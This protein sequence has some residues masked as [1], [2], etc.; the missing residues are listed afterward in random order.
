MD[1]PIFETEHQLFRESASTFV[2]RSVLPHLDDWRTQRRIDREAWLEAGRGG[3]L[4]ISIPEEFGGAGLADD[5]RFNAVLSEE[6]AKASMGLSSSFGIHTDVVAP[7]LIAFCDQDQKERWLPGFCAGDLITAIAMTEP[8]AGSDLAAIKTRARRDGDDW[9]LDGAKTFITNGMSA[10][11]VIIA[12]RTGDERR[13]I[14]L[15]V[16]E[17]AAPGFSRGRKLDKVG[18]PEADTG[19][20]F[21]DG[22]RAPGS[23]LVGEAGS[24][25]AAMM[26]HISQERLHS[27]VANIAHAK[28]HLMNTV[29]YVRDREAFG[30][31]IGSFQSSRF[32]LAEMS[33]LAD[34]TQSYVDNCVMSHID[35]RLSSVEAAKAKWWTAESQNR[36]IDACVQLHGGYGYMNEYEISRA[37]SDARVTKIWA[38]SNEIM[39]ELIGRDMGLGDP[40][41]ARAAAGTDLPRAT[42][43]T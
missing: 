40:R 12:A 3:F 6:L 38:G 43:S 10:D 16:V 25:F 30:Q 33:T 35:G 36:I 28:H 41:P 19:E 42:A 31:P 32:L 4:G 24:G 15:F 20:L 13:D 26:E 2:A 29:E 21:F 8:G 34:V 27:A 37:W 23:S 39:K 5:F 7:Y 11:L 22:L 1:R 9:I 14:S 18:Q 17:S